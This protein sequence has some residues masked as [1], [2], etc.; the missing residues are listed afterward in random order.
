VP[1]QKTFEFMR[2][3]CNW[4]EGEVHAVVCFGFDRDSRDGEAWDVA[5]I[6]DPNYGVERW[7]LDHFEYL[8]DGTTVEVE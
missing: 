8:W 7:S 5:V 6:G 2:D 1:D 4:N 3:Q